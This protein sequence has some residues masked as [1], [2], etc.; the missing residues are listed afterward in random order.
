MTLQNCPI[1][2]LSLPVGDLCVTVSMIF[3]QDAAEREAYNARLR[4]GLAPSILGAPHVP[5]APQPAP[6]SLPPAAIGADLFSS[7][8]S[9]AMSGL[10]GAAPPAPSLP[11]QA[12]A[13]PAPSAARPLI[14]AD[15]LS[16]ALSGAAAP[17]AS[18]DG[19]DF[20]SPE[21]FRRRAAVRE[22]RAAALEQ[23][24]GQSSLF[25]RFGSPH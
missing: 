9:A 16:A 12:S 21:N 25:C 3:L 20:F 11:Q 19:G 4:A 7:A 14:G 15:L 17:S 6:A 1:C 5:A 24:V 23:P 22:Q 8:M 13:Q 2:C 10:T 18:G